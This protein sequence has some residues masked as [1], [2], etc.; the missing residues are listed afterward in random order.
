MFRTAEGL[1]SE[2]VYGDGAPVA[3]TPVRCR[4]RFNDFINEPPSLT[5][6]LYSTI[7]MHIYMEY[8]S[9]IQECREYTVFETVMAENKFVAGVLG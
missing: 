2:G 6:S 3:I 9:H 5:I 8:G 1:I 4:E 7:Y